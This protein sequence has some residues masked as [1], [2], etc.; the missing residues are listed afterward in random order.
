MRMLYSLTPTLYPSPQG[1]GGVFG[2]SWTPVS[3]RWNDENYEIGFYSKVLRQEELL[4]LQATRVFQAN[5][6]NKI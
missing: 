1:G 5:K 2:F 6:N 3:M 4:K